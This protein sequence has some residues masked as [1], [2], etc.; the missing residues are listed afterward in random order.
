MYIKII[1]ILIIK[2]EK[3]KYSSF[4][5]NFVLLLHQHTLS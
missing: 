5:A 4:S 1:I 3:E 2:K